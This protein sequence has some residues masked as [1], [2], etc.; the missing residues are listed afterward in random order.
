MTPTELATLKEAGV[1]PRVHDVLR[2]R[3]SP[4]SF[5]D[6]PVEHSVLALLLEAARWAPSSSNEQP[7]RFIVATRDQPD[8]YARLL[9]CL[10]DRNQIWAKLAPVLMLSVAKTTFIRSERPNRHALHDVGLAT[11]TLIVQATAVGVSVH[12]R[13]GFDSDKARAAFQIP[14][15]F[16]PVAAM[17]VG[18]LG[19]PDRLPDDFRAREIAPRTRR[20]LNETAFSGTWGT[21]F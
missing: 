13:A 8:D 16:E 18:Y 3:W 14:D 11:A 12:P 4:R 10:G 21:G 15:G 5:L 1:D 9:A 17:A 20:P 2:R 19:D 6:R 7:W